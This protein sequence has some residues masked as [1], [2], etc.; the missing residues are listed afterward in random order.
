M[1]QRLERSLVDHETAATNTAGMATN[2]VAPTN[3]PAAD[4]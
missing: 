4:K 2:A 1:R 3:V